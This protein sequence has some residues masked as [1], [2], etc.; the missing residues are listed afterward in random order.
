MNTFFNSNFGK[1]VAIASFAVVLVV[2][3]SSY[4]YKSSSDKEMETNM[5]VVK[6]VEKKGD[7]E[8]KLLGFAEGV[9]KVD[10]RYEAG[11]GYSYEFDRNGNL[12]TINMFD[13]GYT[14]KITWKEGKAVKSVGDDEGFG[15]EEEEEEEP[16]HFEV[17]FDY[18]TN[19][20]TTE[21]YSSVNGEK[22]ELI[23]TM[24]YDEEGRIVRTKS[25]EKTTQFR[26]DEDG[27]AY[28]QDGEEVYPP[29]VLLFSETPLLPKD[30]KVRKADALGRP[31]KADSHDECNH[32]DITYWD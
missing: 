15:E 24:Y 11:F 7:T 19:G 1:M 16:S 32:Y 8:A 4:K 10:F 20:A 26:Y 29:M 18:R 2:L 22:E 12:V 17:V 27:R 6:E 9:K 31:L 5:S 28:N 14:G 30:H 13:H 25:D 23:G 21:I 3:G